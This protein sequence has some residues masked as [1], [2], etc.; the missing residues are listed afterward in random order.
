MQQ[1]PAAERAA[2]MRA[3]EVL[4][5]EAARLQQR[6]GQ[7]IAHHQRGGGARR[8][9]EIVRAGFLRHRDVQVHIGG[10]REG[11]VGRRRSA[12]SA[13]APRRFTCG[14]SASTSAVSPGV[15]QRQQHVAAREHAEVAV[16]GLARDAGR[17]PGVPVLASVA[18]ILRAIWPDLPMPVTTTRPLQAQAACGRRAA[19]APSRRDCSATRRLDLDARCGGRC[20]AAR[21]GRAARLGRSWMAGGSW[22]GRS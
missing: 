13:A 11:R 8:G 16:A 14:S 1:Q 12:R 10:A 5:G 9:G 2:R 21:A 3:G 17:T 6:D 4:G 19:K 18:A 20:A 22:A 7:R 15:G